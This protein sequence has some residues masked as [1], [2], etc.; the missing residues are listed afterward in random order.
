MYRR[1]AV[2]LVALVVSSAAWGT[3]DASPPAAKALKRLS[4]EE[5]M[6]V[7][8]TSVSRTAESLSGAAAA[9]TVVTNEDIRRSGA[10]TLPEALRFVPGLNVARRHASSWG[11]SSRGFSSVNSEKLLVL[12]DT[13][14]IYTPLFSGVA[15]DIQDY[16]LADIERVEIIRGPG[17]ALWGSNAVNGVIN[18]TTK[19]AADTQ[20]LYVEGIAGSE[21]E[22]I[23]AVRYGGRLGESGFFRVFGKHSER[24]ETFQQNPLRSDDWRMSHAGFR[25]DWDHDED[26]A[27]TVQGDF[28]RGNVG[29]LSPSINI[30]G[31]PG[32]TGSLRSRVEGGNVLGRWRH[33]MAA[34]SELQLRVYYDRTRRNDPSFDDDLDT[35]D[36]EAQ[37][38]FAPWQGHDVIWGLNYR[39]TDNRNVGKGV[40]ALQ[41]ASS[42]DNLYSAFVQDQIALME[43]LRVT[44]GTKLEHNDF[45]GFEVQPSA[46]VAWDPVSGHTLWSAVSRAARVPTRIERDIAIDL[47]NPASNPIGRLLGNRDFDAE[48]LIAYEAGYRWHARED[49]LVDVAAFYNRYEDLASLEIG[50]PFISPVDGRIVV[51]VRNQNLT[52]GTAKGVEVLVNFSP[53]PAWRLFASYSYIDLSLDPRGTDLNRGRFLEGATPRH[54]LGLRSL[55]DLPG[56]FQLDAHWRRLT[57]VR[58]LPDN[59]NGGGVPGYAELDVRIAWRGWPRM[60]ISL[61]GQ[62]LLHDHHPEFGTP[63]ARGEIERGVYGKIAWGF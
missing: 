27:L 13:R 22:I 51:P 14:S 16:L 63:A 49:L 4:I 20:D 45:S 6:D 11:V 32:P 8:I 23:S 41:P 54:Q 10:T 12:S 46:R 19:S 44:L 37:H 58:S 21:E 62:N 2:S 40:F 36:L 47:N 52:D 25:A 18:I 28:Y 33:S 39:Y 31:R 26:D 57:D 61:V 24:D 55:L 3:Q 34:D 50:A 42:Q 17:A 53:L 15:W 1:S 7:E 56:D 38:Q 48:E 29:Q 59:V 9:I 5:L 30:I 43:A 60:E 35:I